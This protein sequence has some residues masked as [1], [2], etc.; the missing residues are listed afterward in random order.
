LDAYVEM[1]QLAKSLNE[2]DV[3]IDDTIIITRIVSSLPDDKFLAF[4]KA[5]DSVPEN[6]QAMEMLLARLKKEELV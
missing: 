5:W 3:T 2:M 1:E 6:H 4:K